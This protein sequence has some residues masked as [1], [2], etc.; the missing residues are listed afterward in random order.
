VANLATQV[1]EIWDLRLFQGNR[2]GLLPTIG[3]AAGSASPVSA[4]LAFA[5]ADRCVWPNQYS[6]TTA[7][8]CG[9]PLATIDSA[10]E[11]CPARF[12]LHGWAGHNSRG[13]SLQ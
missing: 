6:I 4:D 2:R 3:S 10:E 5:I 9:K 11:R 13:G 12:D 1:K 7:V 8:S